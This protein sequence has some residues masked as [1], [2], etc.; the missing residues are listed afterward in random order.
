MSINPFDRK[1]R[2]FAQSLTKKNAEGHADVIATKSG[3]VFKDKP[4]TEEYAGV[5]KIA[6][7]GQS[8]AQVVTFLTTAALGVFALTH[9]V[10]LSWGIYIAIPLGLL[11]AFGVENV[12]R[13]T[14]AIAAKHFL[15]YKQF[16]FV[17]VAALLVMC[18]SIA[19]ALYGAKELPGV[20]YPKPARAVDGAAVAA[21][22]ADIDRVQ[23]DIDRLQSGLKSGKNWIAENRTLP[24]L[25]TQRIALIEKR[26]AATKDAAGRGDADHLEALADRQEKVDKMQVYAVGAA[27]VAEL[28]FLLCTAFILYYLFRHYAEV[29][30]EQ[31]SEQGTPQAPGVH[32][33]ATP[34]ILNGTPVASNLRADSNGIRHTIPAPFTRARA[35]DF[36][37]TETTIIV[38]DNRRICEHCKTPYQY[39]H[40][41]QKFCSDG[42]RIASWETQSGKKLKRTKL[43]A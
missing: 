18:V 30:H 28:I 10:P 8:V 23:A 27:I 2:E 26:D 15:K 29:N 20:V 4:F 19:A 40:S 25:Q 6:Q 9:I 43:S 21:L 38:D 1:F 31:E 16:G 33:E 3:E 34:G 5:Y 17:G 37:S 7:V 12:K 42:C 22:T 35:D 39:R 32:V 11:F 14:L 36:R 24:K 13:S 41:K